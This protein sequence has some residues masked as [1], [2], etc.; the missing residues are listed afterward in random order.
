MS[1]IFYA[2]TI[3]TLFSLL[4][5][6]TWFVRSAIKPPERYLSAVSF[7]S[8][9]PTSK[10]YA[11][12]FG[13]DTGSVIS[14]TEHFNDL[15]SLSLNG[16]E[17]DEDKCYRNQLRKMHCDWRL[18][19]SSTSQEIWQRSC[20]ASYSSHDID[21]E[22]FTTCQWQDLLFIAWCLEQYQSFTFSLG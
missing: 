1:R 9:N 5:S 16:L 14:K 18:K 19:N 20:G 13:G 3:N 10:S 17:N 6:S 22:K 21:D 15:W 7:L 8:A 2:N 11:I 12:Q 4:F